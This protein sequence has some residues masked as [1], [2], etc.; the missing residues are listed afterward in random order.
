M[1]L[2]RLTLLAVLG[3]AALLIAAPAS[4][5][6]VPTE[7][8]LCFQVFN[9]GD[10]QTS[11]TVVATTG[12]SADDYEVARDYVP[13]TGTFQQVDVLTSVLNTTVPLDDHW[14]RSRNAQGA[15]P[16]V[17]CESYERISL[18]DAVGPDDLLRPSANIALGL[19]GNGASPTA[20]ENGVDYRIFEGEDDDVIVTDASEAPELAPNGGKFGYRVRFRLAEADLEFLQDSGGGVSW[21]LMQRGLFGDPGG[22][23]KMSIVGQTNTSRVRVECLSSHFPG[24]SD[25]LRATSSLDLS[26]VTITDG[27][28]PWLTASCFMDDSG[29]AGGPGSGED[30]LQVVVAGVGDDEVLGGDV[31][32]VLPS[33]TATCGGGTALNT[34]LFPGGIGNVVT[35]GNKPAC[36]SANDNEDAFVGHV[37]FAEVWVRTTIVP[38]PRCNGLSATVVL[39]LG[40]TPTSGDDVIFG[41]PDADAIVAGA[42]NDTIC[43]EGGDDIIT[44]GPGID[45]IFGGDGEDTISGQGDG[46]EL[47]GEGGID[48]INGGAGDDQIFGGDGDDDLRGQGGN[49]TLEGDAGVDQFFGGSGQDTITTGEGGN[50]GTTQ[51]VQGQ[52]GADTIFGSPQDDVLDGG[53]G[54]DEI[55][56]GAGNDTLNGGRSG[57]TLFGDAGND[58]LF[59][60]PDRDFLSG[61]TGGNDT[62]DG[63]GGRNDSADTTCENTSAVP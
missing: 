16:W 59:G 41:T 57:D 9:D 50:A 23:W 35:V 11:L 25:N 6:G 44:G 42:G 19:D 29:N 47:H 52:S 61:G 26:T 33:G 14:V 10:I 24:T 36:S 1:K 31:G 30:G 54:Q 27:F 49:D 28:T 53:F 21:N 8:L 43:G 62:C 32:T 60:G 48:Q 15:S 7:P 4:A 39:A 34:T 40:H 51:I 55:H 45:T 12:D 20:T 38:V 5:Q 37:D 58:Q 17:S 46:D 56:G 22:Q 18:I 3:V 63:G 2:L 13:A